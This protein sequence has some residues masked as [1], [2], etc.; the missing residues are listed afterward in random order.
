MNVTATLLD[1]G[2]V[3]LRGTRHTT[4][5]LQCSSLDCARDSHFVGSPRF[6][7]FAY[8]LK[9]SL[10]GKG[11]LF[12]VLRVLASTR[13]NKKLLFCGGDTKVPTITI[14]SIS[15]KQLSYFMF[16]LDLHVKFPDGIATK[17]EKFEDGQNG[18]NWPSS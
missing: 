10:Y 16:Y 8:P 13:K 7:G 11:E 5:R 12:I 3:P 14:F 17:E 18:R 1:C 6:A 2:L 15:S 9:F 4:F